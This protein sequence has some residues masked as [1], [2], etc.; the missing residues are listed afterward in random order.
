MTKRKGQARVV[1]ANGTAPRLPQRV[2][3]R[4]R[5]LHGIMGTT[6]PGEAMNRLL[7]LGAILANECVYQEGK[8]W[9]IRLIGRDDSLKLVRMG[10]ELD[11]E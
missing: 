2:E 7:V 11:D 6:T 8:G 9:M 4:L 1:P 5:L 3:E 10:K